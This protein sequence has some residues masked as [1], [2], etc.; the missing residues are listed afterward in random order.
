M[1]TKVAIEP[2]SETVWPRTSSPN[3]RRRRNRPRSTATDPRA[4]RHADA[5]SGVSGTG[6]VN[7]AQATY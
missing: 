6:A 1:A 4:R 7:G 3:S 2:S 5:V